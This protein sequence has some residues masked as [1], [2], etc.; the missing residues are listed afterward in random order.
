VAPSVDALLHE[1]VDA[2]ELDRGHDGADVDGLV[3]RVADAQALHAGA[4][5]GR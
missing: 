5:L 1:A 4:Q 3:E 2:L